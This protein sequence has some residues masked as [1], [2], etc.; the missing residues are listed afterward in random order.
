VRVRGLSLG[1]LLVLAVILVLG[2]AA[3]SLSRERDRLR[4][5]YAKAQLAGARDL[6]SGLEDRLLDLEEDG[7]VVGALVQGFRGTPPAA[8]AQHEQNVLAWF[9]A[10]A[11]VVRHYRS[12]ALYD[13]ARLRV[14]AI[15][16]AERPDVGEALMVLGRAAAAA[17]TTQPHLSGPVEATPGRY[18][19]LYSFAVGPGSVVITVDA[20]RLFQSALRSFPDA[21]AIVV[22]PAGN[23]WSG[24]TPATTCTP[25]TAGAHA[26]TLAPWNADS[27]TLW[28]DERETHAAGLAAPRSVAAW[29]TTGPADFGKWRTQLVASAGS[30]HAR[31]QALASQ[32]IATV[33]GLLTAVGIV[34]ALILKQQRH[35][36]ALTE[37]LRNAE[38]LRSLEGQLIRAE[39]LAT[40]GV[41]AAGIAHEIGTPLGV[42]R[43]RA[44]MLQQRLQAEAEGRA[45]DT[46]IQEID[47]ISLTIRQVLDFSRSQAV[48]LQAVAPEPVLRSVLELL[49][50]R[51]A[52][53]SLTVS[54]TVRPDVPSLAADPNQLQ[55]VLINVILNACDACTK[56]GHIWISAAPSA[57]ESQVVWELRDDGAGIAEEH[58]LAVF[59]PFFTTKKR[60]QGT[61]LGLPVAA[62]IVRNHGGEMGLASR[63]GEGTTVTI[64]WPAAAAGAH[65]HV[66][67]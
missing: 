5:D 38:T 16:P 15:D 19:Y 8:A 39:K 46:I 33:T 34:G 62:G 11:I 7:R 50:H 27:G 30:L 25:R 13:G 3:R 32:L 12:L 6:A 17:A 10:M 63:V 23:E 14:S 45:L 26:F 40:T 2:F 47:R 1:I 56:G 22:D 36:A 58:L 4:D 57:D 43:V 31:E 35:A 51:I 59:D 28:L 29:V 65:S 60:G 44:E 18:F 9:K 41:L 37:R 48:E 61:G 42:I 64:R 67:G 54:A 49:D 24:C 20:P 66:Q 21:R 53:Q 52:A 55:Q